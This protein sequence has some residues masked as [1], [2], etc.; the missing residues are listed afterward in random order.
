MVD[1]LVE[2]V[3]I[4][5]RLMQGFVERL[6]YNCALRKEVEFLWSIR[7]RDGEEISAF[8]LEKRLPIS[9]QVKE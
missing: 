7:Q 4:M 6:K 5:V 1:E 2:V 3:H 9:M 8:G